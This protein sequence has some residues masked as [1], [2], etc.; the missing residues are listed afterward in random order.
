[1]AIGG[2][3][4]ALTGTVTPATDAD[5]PCTAAATP[6]A[7]AAPTTAAAAAST[8]FNATTADQAPRPTSF[9]ATYAKELIE[10]SVCADAETF[11]GNLASPSTHG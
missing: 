5:A 9:S 3:K 7:A 2:E 8:D 11:I 6:T 1:M 4:S 10:Y